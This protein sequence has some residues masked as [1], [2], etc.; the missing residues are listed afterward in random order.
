M[1][2][3][4]FSSWLI[5]RFHSAFFP[6]KPS[7]LLA[8]KYIQWCI[9]WTPAS[10][11]RRQSFLVKRRAC[12]IWRY[13]RKLLPGFV[14]KILI[15]TPI[16]GE[17]SIDFQIWLIFSN[18]L[19]VETNESADLQMVGVAMVLRD[20][21]NAWNCLFVV[22]LLML[23]WTS[24]SKRPGGGNY[25]IVDIPFRYM[26]CYIML[27]ARYQHSEIMRKN[28]PQKIP[29][30]KTPVFFFHFSLTVRDA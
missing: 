6:V 11:A 25:N 30:C 3:H 16:L 21:T 17:H 13:E 14:S 1:E 29:R 19:K 12:G 10:R 27:H 18:G 2:S 15:F 4:K 24:A 9:I 23:R 7:P 26:L 8:R 22:R 28:Q 5:W 20:E